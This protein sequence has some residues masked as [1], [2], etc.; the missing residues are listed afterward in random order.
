MDLT[1]LHGQRQA[2]NRS[3]AT[4]RKAQ[5]AERD[6]TETWPSSARGQDDRAACHLGIEHYLVAERVRRQP[7]M[8]TKQRRFAGFELISVVESVR[9]PPLTRQATW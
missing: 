1:W 3:P 4:T 7:L 6:G 2:Q 8:P 5:V 9:F